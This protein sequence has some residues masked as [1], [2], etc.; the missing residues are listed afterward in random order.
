MHAHYTQLSPVLLLHRK[1]IEHSHPGT[2]I[3]SF[4]WSL[5]HSATASTYDTRGRTMWRKPRQ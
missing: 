1:A 4:A 3:P 2:T 5:A